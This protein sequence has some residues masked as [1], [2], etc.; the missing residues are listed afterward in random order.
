M[1]ALM[2]LAQTAPD[3]QANTSYGFAFFAALCVAGLTYWKRGAGIGC[4]GFAIFFFVMGTVGERAVG[5]DAALRSIIVV[6]V[7]FV[8][9]DANRRFK[10]NRVREEEAAADREHDAQVRAQ[11]AA[12]P[13]SARSLGFVYYEGGIPSM[14]PGEEVELLMAGTTLWLAPTY[15]DVPAVPLDC[16]RLVDLYAVDGTQ[17]VVLALQGKRGR[18]QEVEL[19]ATAD[20]VIETARQLY[21]I[22]DDALPAHG[23]PGNSPAAP[24]GAQRQICGG[25]GAPAPGERCTYCGRPT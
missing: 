5:W 7:V 20:D 23:P 15:P 24:P 25:C 16:T 12:I 8:A 18:N 22:L 1:N 11:R 2:L 3:P 4:L 10:A 21:A 14:E 17:N 19:S 6:A 13:S 9:V